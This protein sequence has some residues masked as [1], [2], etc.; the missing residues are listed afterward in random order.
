MWYSNLYRRHLIDMHID[1]W[2]P[3]F[4]SQFSPEAYVENLKTAQINYA[5]IY[6]Q[7]H[8]GQCYFPTATG[9]LHAGMKNRPDLMKRTVDLCKENGIR[10]CGYYS[11]IY[12]TREH[13]KHPEWRLLQPSGDSDR[14]SRNTTIETLPFASVKPARYGFCCPN[15]PGYREFVFRQ[16]DEMLDFFQ[17]DAMFFDMPFW[18]HLCYCDHCKARYKEFT[19]HEIPVDPQLGTQEYYEVL[20]YKIKFMGE[21]IQGVSDYVKLRRPGMPVE[22]NIAHAVTGVTDFGCVEEVVN[23]CDYVGGDLYGNLYNHS[24]SCKCFRA[25]SAN[26]PFEQMITRCKSGLRVHTV[27]K[28]VDEMKTAISNTMAHHGASLVIDAIDPVGTMDER[29]YQR[30]GEVF[31]FQK[32]YEPWFTGDYVEDIGIYFGMRSRM[33]KDTFHS[34]DCCKLL[35]KALIRAHIPHGVTGSFSELDRYPIIAAPVLSKLEDGDNERLIRY[36]ADGGTLYISYCQN[37]KLVETLTGHKL[38]GMTDEVNLYFAPKPEYQSLFG[39]FNEKYPLPMDN[40]APIVEPGKDATVLATITFPYTKP[41]S[42]QFASIHS[43]PPG[44]PSQIPAITVNSYGKGKVIWSAL[45]L[46]SMDFSD[47]GEILVSLLRFAH[48]MDYAFTSDAPFHVEITAFRN[49]DSITVNANA[50]C[51]DTVAIDVPSFEIRVKTDT[52]PKAV[53]LLPQSDTVSFT[54]ENGYTVFRTRTL[55]IFDMYQI[56]F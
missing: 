23:A 36:V 28:S 32:Q 16:I 45:P 33:R 15:N 43:N 1:D 52:A 14:N 26:Q 13:D 21:F 49:A 53:V 34:R 27:T 44:I 9:D 24:F 30:I 20:Q 29:V 2:S 37:Q 48:P 35:S 54:Y 38:L 7:S 55:H 40:A 31:D 11:L 39:W 10:V 56:Q 22:H 50:L 42:P 51:E 46:E 4:L 6:F 19:G 3:E 41:D 47:H 12:N 5:M 8:A 17:P 25:M 18:P